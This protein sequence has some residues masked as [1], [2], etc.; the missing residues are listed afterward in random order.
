RCELGRHRDGDAVDLRRRGAQPDGEGAV[1]PVARAGTFDYGRRV[2]AHDHLAE[3]GQVEPPV[4]REPPM[5]AQSLATMPSRVLT[6]QR[7]S[8]NR[9]VRRLLA[10]A[11]WGK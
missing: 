6:L 11:T 3:V 7:V 5:T 10:R 8:G 1:G 9:S 2:S 4:A